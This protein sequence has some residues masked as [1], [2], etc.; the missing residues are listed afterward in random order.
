[1]RRTDYIGDVPDT[2]RQSSATHP[3]R[4]EKVAFDESASGDEF[5]AV[6]YTRCGWMFDGLVTEFRAD[7]AEELLDEF[8]QLVRVHVIWP[9]HIREST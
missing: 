3:G 1:M 6:A 8:D 7:V 5:P 9:F 2:I 4:I